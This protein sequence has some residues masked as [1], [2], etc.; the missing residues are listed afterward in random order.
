VTTS[1]VCYSTSQNFAMEFQLTH[2]DVQYVQWAIYGTRG[3]PLLR[4]VLDMISKGG[5]VGHWPYEDEFMEIMQRTGPGYFMLLLFLL[6]NNIK[7]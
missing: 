3:H 6:K 7:K 4:L 5:N 2:A 1:N